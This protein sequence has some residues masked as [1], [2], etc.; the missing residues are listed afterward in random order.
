MTPFEL[1]I[2]LHRPVFAMMQ[3]G[4]RVDHKLKDKLTKQYTKDWESAQQTLNA[5]GGQPIN[6]QSPKQV[7][8]LMYDYLELPVR[9]L[10][11]QPT[12]NEDAIRASIAFAESKAEGLKTP[13]AQ[14]RWKHASLCLQLVLRIREYRKLL[15]SYLNVAV[16]RD[17]RIRCFMTIGGTETMRFSHSKTLWGTGL[18]LA[19]VPHKLRT[20]F[21]ADD[22]YELAELDLNRGESW[23][24]TFLSLDPELRRI[25]LEGLDFH[26]ETAAAIQSAFG[27]KNLTPT[28]IAQKAK[29]GDDFAYK[30]R[31]LGK[32]VN[33][34]SA[35]RMGPFRAAEVINAESDDTGITVVPA[36]TK[37]AQRLWRQKYIGIERWWSDIDRQLEQTRT[38]RTPYG[39]QQRFYAF[40]GDHLKKSATA[41]VPQSTSVDY[42]NR[43]MLR[44]FEDLVVPGRLGLQLLHQNHDSILIQYPKE[45]RDEIIPLVKERLLSIVSINGHNVTIPVE[46]SCGQNWGDWNKESN[47]GGLKEY[48]G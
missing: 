28:E 19:T 8:E 45:R 36:Q 34:A 39:R 47:P 5:I 7:K 9:R 27:G 44:V 21:V 46:A 10:R 32:R 3:R 43:G 13:T 30:L 17:G 29:Q 35:Y 11:G 25:H 40:M 24:Y 41:Y 18:N 26:S 23:V 31:Y 16:D 37:D 48:N 42:L 22:G 15:S 6:V 4:I 2:A 20:M 1:D 38:L 14:G 33:H 12:S